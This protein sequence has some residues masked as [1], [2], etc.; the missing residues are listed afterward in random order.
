MEPCDLSR[1]NPGAFERLVRALCFA[2]FGPGGTV[3][4]PGPDGGRDFTHEGVVPGYESRKWNGY[5]VVQA[6][7]CLSPKGGIEDAKW[8]IK[9]LKGEEGKYKKNL[10]ILRKPQYYIIATNINLSGA[11]GISS[12]GAKRNGGHTK[13]SSFIDDWKK[14]IGILDF[15]IW[16]RDKI[17]DLL[18]GNECVRRTY[19]AWV[20][21]GDVLTEVLSQLQSRQKNFGAIIRRSLKTSLRRDQFARLKDAGSV[22]DGQVRTSQ[23]FVDLPV[24]ELQYNK[25]QQNLVSALIDRSKNVHANELPENDEIGDNASE[26]QSKNKIV[27]LGGPG[28]GKSTATLFFSQLLR[29]FSIIRDS[30]YKHD[31]NIKILVPEIID[32]AR[33]EGISTE[34]PLRYPV[35]V[36]LPR[37]ADAISAAK[38]KGEDPP[39]LL[40]H[41]SEN[42]SKTS[43]GTID[44]DDLRAWLA[45]YPWLV[46][47]DGLDE[48]PPSGE[49]EAV[50]D[51][52]KGFISE[53]ADANADV[54]LIVTTRP[55][56]YNDDLDKRSWEHWNLADL[57]AERALAYAEALGQAQYPDDIERREYI[58]DRLLRA[59]KQ[60]ATSRLMKSPLQVTILHLIVDTGG[61]IPAARWA[62]FNEYF[63]VLKRR[64][65]SKGGE[66]QRAL[67]KNLS[68]IGPIHQRAGLVLQINSEK[69][70]SA[71][72]ALNEEN[73]KLLLRNYLLSEGY[74]GEAL[75][76]RVKEL[77]HLALHRLVLLSAREEGSISFDVRSLQEY[78]A[79]A[80]LTS[81]EHDI[82][83][84][85]LLHITGKAH[86]Q[87]VFLIAA[88]R[89][90]AED[91]FHHRRSSVISIARQMEA[92]GADKIVR[93]GA[94]LALE[95]FLDGIGADHPNYRRTLCSHAIELLELGEANID[96][97]LVKLCEPETEQLINDYIVEK[98]CQKS[99]S[100]LAAW[101]FLVM[102]AG[103]GNDNFTHLI[104][105][106]WP[107]S[108]ED[109]M[110]IIENVNIYA[111][112]RVCSDRV[113]ATLLASDPSFAERVIPEKINDI[114]AGAISPEILNLIS[115]L[116]PRAGAG[117]LHPK[118]DEKIV[119]KFSPLLQ[120][121]PP[122]PKSDIPI[123]VKWLIIFEAM[124][125][126]ANSNIADAA[127]WLRFIAS[128]KL[129][130]E[131]KEIHE[132]IPWPL[133]SIVDVCKQDQDLHNIAD[134]V[135][136]GDFG[137]VQDWAIAERRWRDFGL[138]KEDLIR[139]KNGLWFD[140]NVATYGAFKWAN[141]YLKID[142]ENIQILDQLIDI[143]NQL[144]GHHRDCVEKLI[145]FASIGGG[146]SAFN[147]EQA[148][149]VAEFLSI[150]DADWLYPESFILFGEQALDDDWVAD[151]LNE[152]AARMHIWP[153][154]SLTLL[155]VSSYIQAFMRQ[156]SRR[157]LL[158]I[159]CA[160]IISCQNNEALHQ[161]SK[162]SKTE[163][164]TRPEDT[165]IVRSSINLLR[166]LADMPVEIEP[167]VEGLI[168]EGDPYLGMVLV[169]FLAD[170]SLASRSLK[171]E[172][173]TSLIS[174]CRVIKIPLDLRPELQ[175][176]LDGRLSN[177]DQKEF[178]IEEAKFPRDSFAALS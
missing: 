100:S 61:S 173:L 165:P 92:F 98:I 156:P 18:S 72:S 178:W 151:K 175:K 14:S 135:E 53:I 177:F 89:C 97:R 36:I 37:F 162:I 99:P 82:M 75:E 176:C 67:E 158:F 109:A 95:L 24:V 142:S 12:E 25:I 22:S 110:N 152:A 172:L 144:S 30:S 161:L 130:S 90:F 33:K 128:E 120:Q 133:S 134:K 59:S 34:V 8:L 123:H 49:R 154:R 160:N 83:E 51:G 64:E 32:R 112:S 136:A 77:T 111:L 137:T 103:S 157:N 47:L 138:T 164:V 126:T 143:R 114:S 163:L 56:G 96:V 174:A 127:K 141:L 43:D 116:R 70:G 132:Y 76:C 44:R 81:G 13:V 57:P 79:A 21:P 106:L 167:V 9:Q 5:L 69:R 35:H 40:A 91:A 78:M 65:K 28:Q 48:V 15:D 26:Y 118:S 86:W 131:T 87:H 108:Q 150:C 139:C 169:S 3:F 54:L 84:K 4:S 153:K 6:K 101:K 38:E 1:L 52:I 2:Q 124:K 11:D 85:R 170:G 7:F 147:T 27:L 121:S 125:I 148:R 58:S 62:L 80:A 105:R 60:A 107:E 159:I 102:I 145:K 74:E 73:F 66:T 88:S 71:N 168:S 41:I 19:A 68:H 104:G 20:T 122:Q 129:I 10:S 146:E 171:E 31:D 166:I 16:P 29:A 140:K 93:N 39:S 117:V 55:Q 23:V 113:L 115:V 94:K 149:K 155:S 17:I 46:V 45:S 50:I 63:D 119:A 42:L